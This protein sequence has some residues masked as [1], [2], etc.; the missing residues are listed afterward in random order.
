M[1]W[2][3][4]RGAVGLQV[5]G[6]R[7]WCQQSGRPHLAGD[8]TLV[9][10]VAFGIRLFWAALIPPW[11]SPDEPQHF[12]YI[13]HIVENGKIPHADT[14]DRRYPIHS[15]EYEESCAL[16]L[17]SS[18]SGLG[19]GPGAL[20]YYPVEHDYQRARSFAAPAEQRKTESGS[21]ATTYPP[22]YYLLAS[23]PYRLFYSAPILTRALMVRAFGSI[24]GALACVFGYLFAYELR[25]SKEWGRSIGLSLSLM[26]MYAFIGA[27]INNDTAMFAATAALCWLLARAWRRELSWLDCA[28]IGLVAG[29]A[30]LSKHTSAPLVVIA[31]L[32]VLL[33]SCTRPAKLWPIPRSLFIENGAFVAG[34]MVTEGMWILYRRLHAVPGVAV[35]QSGILKRVLGRDAYSWAEYFRELYGRGTT[36]ADWL[37]TRTFWGY[38]GWL[39]ICFSDRLYRIIYVLTIVAGI[40]LLWRGLRN[41]DERRLLLALLAAVLF[42]VV[43]LFLAADYLLAFAWKGKSFGMQ[44]RYFF[45]T[46]APHIFLFTSGL[47]WFFR[48]RDLAVRY[49]PVL[50]LLLHGAAV[51]A[52]LNAYYGIGIG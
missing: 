11:M 21:A 3:R 5:K 38:F 45:T 34:L 49:V 4:S 51:G 42:N 7:W 24:L 35:A 43:L 46:L 13:A 20:R 18:I 26:P 6:V 33:R 2:D 8:L 39:E 32:A 36:Y 12:A 29:L 22:L 16:T 52:M 1:R 44:G 17:C 23:I 10:L 31:G 14:P 27:S 40:G 50:M 25:G 37:F 47:V 41:P 30:L 19:R 15:R 9:F 48:D 28:G